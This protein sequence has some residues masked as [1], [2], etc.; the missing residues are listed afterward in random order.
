MSDVVVNVRLTISLCFFLLS[1]PQSRWILNKAFV[2]LF[3]NYTITAPHRCD[4]N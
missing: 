2:E 4:K 3:S 1:T